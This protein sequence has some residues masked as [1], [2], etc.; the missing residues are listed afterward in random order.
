MT[1]LLGE[2]DR[3]TSS[4]YHHLVISTDTSACY[5]SSCDSSVSSTATHHHAI[6]H[7]V[8]RLWVRQTHIIML[9]QPSATSTLFYDNLHFEHVDKHFK[10]DLWL[11][12]FMLTKRRFWRDEQ[13][14]KCGFSTDFSTIRS[15]NRVLTPLKS[16]SKIRISSF[17]HPSK[18]FVWDGYF[19]RNVRN[20]D[21][22]KKRGTSCRRLWYHHLVISTDTSACYS[23]SCDS[24]VSSTDTHHHVIHH[25]VIRVS[26]NDTAPMLRHQC[27]EH[28]LRNFKAR[29]LT[30]K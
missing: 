27:G 14:M 6:H 4:C 18:I 16:A 8:I 29:Y 28:K 2:F 26:S 25:L 21:C 30:M 10:V 24:S 15:P 11:T 1:A 13:K 12:L 3:H 22:Q 20:G 17:V 9:L 7:L 23:S 5:S 19:C